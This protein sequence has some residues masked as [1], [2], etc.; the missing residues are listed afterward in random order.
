MIII[1]ACLEHQ[2]TY[3]RKILKVG[4]RRASHPKSESGKETDSEK[5]IIDLLLI[6]TFW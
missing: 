2:N 3:Y 6:L 5:L 4:F 1:D